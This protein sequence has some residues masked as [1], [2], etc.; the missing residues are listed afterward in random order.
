M[1]H[2]LV[3][4]QNEYI[5]YW[6]S[7]QWFLYDGV[8]EGPWGYHT[9]ATEGFRHFPCC[10]CAWQSLVSVTLKRGKQ[11]CSMFFHKPPPC[12]GNIGWRKIHPP[13]INVIQMAQ[14]VASPSRNLK[15]NVSHKNQNR[16]TAIAVLLTPYADNPPVRWFRHTEITKCLILSELVLW[17]W[18][19]NNRYFQ[20]IWWILMFPFV[21][22]RQCHS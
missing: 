21:N 16:M 18:T 5:K 10:E 20:D 17:V 7:M 9:Y 19:T 11:T 3:W 2:P 13:N 8:C 22:D 1:N 12:N 4:C 15:P 14:G 6:H